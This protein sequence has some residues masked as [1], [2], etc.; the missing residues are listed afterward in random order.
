VRRL[1]WRE[2]VA[3]NTYWV[4]IS[5]MW[6]S[7]HGL[8]LPVVLLSLV[9]EDRKNTYLGLL[10]FGG[11]LIATIVQPVAGALSDHWVSRW[12]RR[13][14][15]MLLGTAFDFVFLVVLAWAGGLP[16]LVLGYVGLQLSSNLAHGPL[17]GLLPDRVPANQMGVA[18]GVK[19]LFDMAGLIVASLVVGRLLPAGVTQPVMAMAVVAATLAVGAGITLA[20][21]R[22]TPALAPAGLAQP[23]AGLRAT[24]RRLAG[25]RNYWWL[26]AT[27]FVFLLGITGVQTFALYFVRDVLRPANPAELTGN[28]LA[29]LALSLTA[30][31]LLGG[32]LCDHFGPQRLQLVACAISAAGALLLLTVHSAEALLLCGT[33]LGVGI[34]LFLT[35]NW[36][37]A[38]SLAPIAEAGTFLGLTNLATA[39]AGAASRLEGPLID[40]LNAARP[41]AFWGYAMLFSVCAA[42][43]LLAMLLTRVSARAPAAASPVAEPSRP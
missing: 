20:G 14:P 24:A 21:A 39:G 34:G 23:R 40:L 36:T 38:N 9:P 2:I 26:I 28:L 35:A 4:G 6:N 30:F 5:F 3:L 41:G 8:V 22:E 37:L 15:L 13:R 17:Q 16:G 1:N 32:W 31:A 11:L 42:C 18:S 10:T 25:H 19:N 12:G 33:V 29:A 43:A 27:R 7:L